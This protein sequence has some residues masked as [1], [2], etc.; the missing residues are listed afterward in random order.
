MTIRDANTSFDYSTEGEIS[1]STTT[2]DSLP[3]ELIYS[4]ELKYLNKNHSF[5]LEITAD[6]QGLSRKSLFNGI[7]TKLKHT[8]TLAPLQNYLARQQQFYANLIRFLNHLS[9]YI[10]S[11]D[12]QIIK[13]IDKDVRQTN[14]RL[15][16]AN[17]DAIAT[18]RSSERSTI[19]ALNNGMHELN[20]YIATLQEKSAEHQFKLDTLDSITKGLEKIVVQINSNLNN[21]IDAKRHISAKA[22]PLDETYKPALCDLDYSYLLLENRFR[23]SEDEIRKRLSIYPPIFQGSSKPI[24]EIGSGRGELQSLFK[25]KN[26]PSYG[27]DLDKAM[28]EHCRSM[29]L[30]VRFEN[31]MT[32]LASLANHSL[33]GVIAIQVIEHLSQKQITEL[34]GLC[35]DKVEKG[36]KVVF[37]TIN[38]DSMIALTRNYF[39]DPTHVWPLHPD[40]MSF[41]INLQGL[42]VV[43]VRK[44]SPF[45]QNAELCEIPHED[46]MTPKWIHSVNLL[47]RNFKLLNELLFG[48]QDYCVIAEV[49]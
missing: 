28:V 39:R 30:D 6:G 36:G 15:E 38:S 44:L 10:D 25:V 27:L 17:D 12:W 19:E 18:I 34:I 4:D 35:K 8:L 45:P 1:N 9:T 20:L 33:G 49:E 2:R 3:G 32:H 42:K 11:R 26:I 41:L 47:N 13:K 37:E 21:I 43:E 7:T 40:T 31:G 5:P 48:Y 23:G 16:R 14:E 46:Y 22:P 24:L 29:D